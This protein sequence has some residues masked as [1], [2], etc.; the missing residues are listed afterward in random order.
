MWDTESGKE[1]KPPERAMPVLEM[2]SVRIF[3]S[4]WAVCTVPHMVTAW[5]L[6]L[7][8][9]KLE[10]WHHLWFLCIWKSWGGNTVGKITGTGFLELAQ[11]G[12]L[13]LPEWSLSIILKMSSRSFLY[14][15]SVSTKAGWT[16]VWNHIQEAIQTL[17]QVNL[18]NRICIS[19]FCLPSLTCQMFKINHNPYAWIPWNDTLCLAP[20]KNQL[21][22]G[23]FRWQG[24]GGRS[25]SHLLPSVIICGNV[26]HVGKMLHAM[27]SY[28]GFAVH[29]WMDP[30]A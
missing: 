23:T 22:S 24:R 2:G 17:V 10:K 1:K 26:D 28:K 20:R 30:A 25:P 6:K 5:L 16:W 7:V 4:S 13:D 19:Q 29:M 15:H 8:F 21:K 9:I 3:F 11:W 18:T 12:Y 27:S 14:L